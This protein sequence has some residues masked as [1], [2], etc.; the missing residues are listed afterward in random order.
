MW[1]KLKE[2]WAGL[3]LIASLLWILAHLVLI[4]IYG[5]ITITENNWWILYVELIVVSF[6]LI[7]AIERLV[8]DLRR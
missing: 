1:D 6:L 2:I 4:K 7:L 8:G 3:L 5:V